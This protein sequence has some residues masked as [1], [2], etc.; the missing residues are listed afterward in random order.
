MKYVY[1]FN[2]EGTDVYKIG[3]SKHPEKRLLQLQTGN[4]TK[5]EFVNSFESNY[6]TQLES[7]LHR[8]FKHKKHSEDEEKLQGE[9]F[10]LDEYDIS[11]FLECCQKFENNMILLESSNT[12][13]QD[14]KK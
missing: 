7:F 6:A 9:F 3:H 11:G 5:I 8:K 4:P 12:Y 10:C 1:L 13:I 14:K 2:V